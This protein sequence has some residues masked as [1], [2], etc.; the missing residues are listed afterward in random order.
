MLQAIADLAVVFTPGLG[1]FNII[2]GQLDVITAFS[3]YII[4]NDVDQR[5]VK[6][7]LDHRS[8]VE[9]KTTTQSILAASSKASSMAQAPQQA[10][11]KCAVVLTATDD[12]KVT[13]EHV[14]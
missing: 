5:V 2:V 3:H 1:L 10:P 9:S 11:Q 12:T 8:A 13:K 14:A 7:M 6:N 4:S